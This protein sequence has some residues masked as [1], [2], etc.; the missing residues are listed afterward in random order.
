LAFAGCATAPQEPEYQL[1]GLMAPG[2]TVEIT[3][4]LE[5]PCAL[6][7]SDKFQ[8][9]LEAEMKRLQEEQKKVLPQ[10]KAPAPRKD[11]PNS[12]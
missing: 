7:K 11:N 1:L 12:I 8:K 6:F 3:C 5:T 4:D 2:E 10:M 9:E